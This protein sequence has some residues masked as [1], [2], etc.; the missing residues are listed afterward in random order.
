MRSNLAVMING[1]S[2][3]DNGVGTNDG[4]RLDHSVGHDLNAGA[5]ISRFCNRGGRVN[6]ACEIHS[7]AGGAFQW[8]LFRW[9]LEPLQCPDPKPI[10]PAL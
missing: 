8:I 7:A 4:S 6:D 1:R 2:C 9:Q 3:I 5:D 10:R